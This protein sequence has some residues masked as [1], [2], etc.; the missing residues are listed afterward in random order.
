MYYSLIKKSI[1][2]AINNYQK[3]EISNNIESK[4]NCILH[5]KFKKMQSFKILVVA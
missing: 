5:Y 4:N 1:K 2:K 3:I